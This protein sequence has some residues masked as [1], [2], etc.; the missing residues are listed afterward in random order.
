MKKE[1]LVKGKWYTGYNYCNDIWIFRFH[2]LDTINRVWSDRGYS[3]KNDY[4]SH[5]IGHFEEMKDIEVADEG[6]IK[7][8]YPK[9]LI[10]LNYEIY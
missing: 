1:E 2:H 8:Y 9:E 7:L 5:I 10:Q 4:Y 3:I 6:I